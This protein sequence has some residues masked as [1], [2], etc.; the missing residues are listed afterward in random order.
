MKG[1]KE[2]TGAWFSLGGF[3]DDSRGFG[4]FLRLVQVE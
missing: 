3:A 2:Y 4:H 1:N